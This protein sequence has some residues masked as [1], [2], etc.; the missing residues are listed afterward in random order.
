VAKREIPKKIL[1]TTPFLMMGDN[2]SSIT[3]TI[4]R[5]MKRAEKRE[6][7]L[8]WFGANYEDP[9]HRLPYESAEGGYQ[10]VWG[11]PYSAEEELR[12]IF[13]GFVPRTLIAEV[14]EE[15]ESDG[16]FDWAPTPRR[17]DYVA[18]DDDSDSLSGT[19][20]TAGRFF[21]SKEEIS[22][23]EDVLRALWKLETI[24]DL[25]VPGIGHNHPPQAIDQDEEN[26]VSDIRKTARDLRLELEKSV[27]EIGVTKRLIAS[28]GC[29]L[30]VS[31]KWSA[32]KADIVVDEALK[33]V[34][35]V[36]VLA[37]ALALE[38]NV[39]SFVREI[40]NLSVRW[41]HLATNA[42]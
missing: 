17:G 37:P 35:R 2:P 14:V 30:A 19:P 27:P 6:V 21:G 20:D 5:R 34:A 26:N 23:R 39:Q 12:D 32:K 40:Y 24:P 41:L 1:K 28:I 42:F 4:F 36:A 31:A 25:K 15:V 22:A 8:E 38:P 16:L 13:E 33:N 3:R 29:G 18:D 9:V 11:G 7:M 10:W